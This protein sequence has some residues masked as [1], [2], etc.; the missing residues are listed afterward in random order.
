MNISNNSVNVKKKP[1]KIVILIAISFAITILATVLRVLSVLFFFDKHIAYYEIDALL[2]M[3]ADFFCALSAVFFAVVA[4]FLITEKSEVTAPHTI[5]RFAALIPGAAILFYSFVFAEELFTG[6]PYN[7]PAAF[8]VALFL[9]AT[10]SV[11]FFFSI[12]FTDQPS[13]VSINAGVGIIV[14]LSLRWISSYTNFD[15][16]MNSPLKLFFHFGCIGA[17]LLV[18]AEMRAFFG[19]EKPK[20]YFFS[21][22]GS[23]LCLSVSTIPAIVGVLNKSFKVYPFIKDDLVLCGLLI[24]AIVRAI[25][26]MVHKLKAEKA[27]AAEE[28]AQTEVAEVESAEAANAEAEV[29]EAET[30]VVEAE[31][32]VVEAEA[33][34]A[35]PEAAPIE[36]APAAEVAEEVSSEAE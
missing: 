35:E 8:S 16:P 33:E 15:V 6:N 2:P 30:E 3:V 10:F 9:A 19:I 11:I 34:I 23:I 17:A 28:T 12:L 22:F 7:I 21:L 25:E 4:T 13:A 31:T 29:V 18:V 1:N 26:L 14:W 27:D 32:E 24:Y 5:S 20:F 36:E